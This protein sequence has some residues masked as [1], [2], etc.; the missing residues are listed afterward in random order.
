MTDFDTDCTQGLSGIMKLYLR[1]RNGVSEI[2]ADQSQILVNL[3][4]NANL[5]NDVCASQMSLPVR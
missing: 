5:V 1:Q 2:K 3:L 4:S